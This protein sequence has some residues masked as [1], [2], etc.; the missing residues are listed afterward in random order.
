MEQQQDK[1][2]PVGRPKLIESPQQLWLL[3]R[4]YKEWAKANPRKKEDFVGKDG[5]RVDRKLE[6]PLT[7]VGFE[8]YL[9]ERMIITDLGDYERNKDNRYAEFA[10]IIRAI[11]N[12]IE[13][14]QFEGASVGIYQHNII[15]RKLGLADKQESR[16]VDKDGNDIKPPAQIVFIDANDDNDDLEIKESEE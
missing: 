4:K 8:A 6:R 13:T 12:V 14:D 10:T 3:F 9:F 5:N 7:F 16:Q 11:K 2:N 15:A 1:S